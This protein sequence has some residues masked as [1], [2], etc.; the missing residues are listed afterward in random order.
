LQNWK[1]NTY[2]YNAAGDLASK[3]T[4][5]GATSY[6]YDVQGNLRKVTLANGKMIDYA[7]DPA[8]RRTGK[9]IN[10][11]LQWQLIWLTSLRPLACLKADNTLDQTYYYG[12]K[13]NVPEAMSTANG[14][15]YRIISDQNGNVH[16][17]GK[18]D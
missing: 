6:Q 8:G 10:G 9:K 7:I 17:V 16:L 2:I 11:A 14:K 15:T 4:P 1:G 12:D 18:N 5:S 3:T 13:P